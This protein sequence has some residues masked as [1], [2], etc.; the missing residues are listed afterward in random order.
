M[1][2]KNSVINIANEVRENLL[3]FFPHPPVDTEDLILK[4][5]DEVSLLNG[6]ILEEI[7]DM[8]ARPQVHKDK[9]IDT[10]KEVLAALE[11]VTE[12]NFGDGTV[13]TTV[14]SASWIQVVG[15]K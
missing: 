12:G 11:E 13:T 7:T 1:P 14:S 15:R 6:K 9:R 10:R 3:E 8:Q 2:I 5:L 4:A